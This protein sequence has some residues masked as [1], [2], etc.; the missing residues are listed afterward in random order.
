MYKIRECKKFM[1]PCKECGKMFLMIKFKKQKTNKD[2][3]INICYS[4]R[5]KKQNF[6]LICKECGKKFNSKKKETMF[7]SKECLD[8]YKY[9]N[10]RQSTKCSC[11]GKALI[12]TNYKIKNNKEIFCSRKCYGEWRKTH[13][14]G[15]NSA[16]FN[17]VIT[18][19][20]YCG[21][22]FLTCL[23]KT[24]HGK[25]HFCSI[26]C[27]SKWQSINLVGE[28][29][30]NYKPNLTDEDRQERRLI[31]GYSKWVYNVKFKYKFTCQCCGDN[32]G[33]NLESHHLNSYNWDKENRTNID[34]GVCLCKKC[35]KLFHKIYGCGNNTKE[36]FEEFKNRYQNREFKEVV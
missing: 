2:G 27:K 25:H 22:E 20:D 26:S 32:K 18:K 33:G 35:H 11:C 16:N 1:K 19:C 31:E 12:V 10:D 17:S 13:C 4:C 8:K 15:E 29:G 28:N 7:C 3:R 6:K 21:K 14:T 36:Q 30:C 5:Y 23:S 24:K 9:S 34:N